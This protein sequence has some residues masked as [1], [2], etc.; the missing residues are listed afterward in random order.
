MFS[1]RTHFVGFVVADLGLCLNTQELQ[2]VSEDIFNQT[3][4]YLALYAEKHK[5]F[6][7]PYAKA[8]EQLT[9]KLKDELDKTKDLNEFIASAKSEKDK[10]EL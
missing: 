5:D 2:K 8:H 10:Y 3:A 9:L 4:E 1:S 7:G 6:E